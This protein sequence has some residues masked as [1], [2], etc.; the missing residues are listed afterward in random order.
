M[1]NL[2]GT[3]EDVGV[4]GLLSADSRQPQI[5]DHSVSD[6]DEEN[7][8]SKLSAVHGPYMQVA[9]DELD[10]DGTATNDLSLDMDDIILE[11]SSTSFRWQP[12]LLANL[13]RD[14]RFQIG[15]TKLLD[16][17]VAVKFLKFLGLTYVSI[18]V[19]YHYVRWMQ[20]ENDR[21]YTLADFFT[22]ESTLVALD[23]M[24]F[25]I[26]GRLF[27]QRGVDCL[28]WILPMLACNLYSS[29]LTTFDF[30]QHS[31][32]LYE[33]HCRWSWKL[34]AFVAVVIPIVVG[35]VV[36]HVDRAV[37]QRTVWMQLFE[38]LLCGFFFLA[39]YVSS[40]YFHL[41]HWYVGWL[42]GMH[43]NVDT[44]WSR[45]VMA[46]CWGAYVNGIA[47]YGR[48]P[49]LTC[50]YAYFLSVDQHCP[51]MKCYWDG[52]AEAHDHPNDTNHTVVAPMEPPDWR[53]CSAE[54]YHP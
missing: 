41:H 2:P 43:F 14:D 9:E 33:M 28:A 27:Q 38:L 39:P 7:P 1:T 25:F 32:T 26:V 36:L 54:A 8:H 16:G 6:D 31:A 35:V 15:R 3:E 44:W 22:Y 10:G 13:L 29:Y 53:N 46:W 18:V 50:G 11:H 5:G 4:S 52:L 40:P 34:W 37:R 51:Y 17:A 49:V 47:V 24:M 30:L 42:V 23:S 20:W 48:D 12:F 45:M 21:S 19:M